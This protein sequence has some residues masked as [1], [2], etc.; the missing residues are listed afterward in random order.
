RMLRLIG[1]AF[2][3]LA[4]YLAGQS[5]VVLAAAHHARH[6]PVGI[7]WT[8]TT[9]GVMFALAAG[10]SRTGAALENP[11]LR[12]EGRVTFIDGVLALAV[13]GGLVLNPALG[14]CWADPVAG[15]V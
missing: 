1:I 15:Y 2:V 4:I 6:S 11:V 7:V 9:A 8:A 14:W 13:L 10:K 3:G 5:T 12:A